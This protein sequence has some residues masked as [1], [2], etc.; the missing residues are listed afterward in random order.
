M[1]RHH[2][3]SPRISLCMI[4][5]DEATMLPDCLASV[6]GAVDELVI[7]DTGSTDG[8]QRLAQEAGAVLLTSA[9]NDDFAT[10]RNVGLR[11]ATGDWALILDADERLVRGAARVIRD[12]VRDDQIDCGLLPLHNAAREDADVENVR[13]GQ[14]R[15]AEV[16]YLPRLLRRLPDL[17]FEGI[18]HENVT[19][20]LLPRAERARILPGADIVHLGYAASVQRARQKYARDTALLEKAIARDPRDPG[21]Y[22][23]LALAHL[24]AGRVDRAEAVAEAG[25]PRLPPPSRGTEVTALRLGVARAALA[26]DRGDRDRALATLT[27]AGRHWPDHPDLWFLRGCTAEAHALDA[28]TAT[29]RTEALREAENA[30]RRAHAGRDGIFAQRLLTGATTWATWLRRGAIALLKGRPGEARDAF[31]HADREGAPSV[32][33]D[34][35]RAE[36]ALARRQPETA[37]ALVRRALDALDRP[38]ERD[39]PP[40]ARADAHLLAALVAEAEGD[41]R[42]MATQLTATRRHLGGGSFAASHRRPRFFDAATVLALH[43]GQFIDAPGPFGQLS[44]LLRGETRAVR[45]GAARPLDPG[46]RDRLFRR[47]ILSGRTE[48]LEHLLRPEAEVRLPGLAGALAAV[49]SDLGR[50]RAVMAAS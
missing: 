42:T 12:A 46:M 5:R 35:G 26:L 3:A 9:W 13:G 40:R 32:L 1:S 25:W 22:G 44:V 31:E 14:G 16:S 49:V 11:A 24:E 34:L 21:P 48:A 20:W 30:F 15:R 10:P 4:V 28:E 33:C 47:W 23:Y 41:L 39:V 17:A 2:P 8:T 50:D 27:T 19:P 29:E 7:V 43:H 45:G 38:D 37:R 36:A 6:A 18:V